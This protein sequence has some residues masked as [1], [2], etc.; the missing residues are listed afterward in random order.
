MPKVFTIYCHG[1]GQCRDVGETEIVNYFGHPGAQDEYVDY[2]MLDG[3]GS[4]PKTAPKAGSF[5]FDESSPSLKRLKKKKNFSFKDWM[6]NVNAVANAVGHGV[7][8]NVDFAIAVLLRMEKLPET[9]NMIGWSR[10]AVTALRLANAIVEELEAPIQFNIF[11][12]DPVAGTDHGTDENTPGNRTIPKEVKN[13]LAV[14]ATGENRNTFSP[15]DADRIEVASGDSN[16]VFL[17]FPGIHA[18]VAERKDPKTAEVSNVVWSMAYQFLTKFGTHTRQPKPLVTGDAAYLAEYTQI[19][20]KIDDYAKVKQ[21]GLKQMIIGKGFG[22]RDFAKKLDEYV[23]NPEYF[24]N[25]HHRKCFKALYP[26]L[27]QYLFGRN[28]GKKEDVLHELNGM[29]NSDLVASLG[30]LGV[31]SGG[32]GQPFELPET[33][34]YYEAGRQAKIQYRGSLHEMGIL[35]A[36]DTNKNAESQ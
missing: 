7:K 34:V 11:A 29:K 35:D 23:V 1:S 22:T 18:T 32:K 30:F 27:F 31:G 10:G 24:I 16:V 26:H 25:H 9:I 21:K 5:E 36:V 14:L 12:V 33:G 3:V 13:Y 28:E 15:Q 8:A 17:P 20:L 19:L 4:K 2:L 6:T